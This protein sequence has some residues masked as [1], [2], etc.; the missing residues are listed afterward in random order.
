MEIPVL[1][2]FER[3]KSQIMTTH[4]NKQ[5]EE[6]KWTCILCP[7]IKKKVD[8]N[9]EFSKYSFVDGARDGLFAVAEMFNATLATL[10]G[11]DVDK[12]TQAHRINSATISQE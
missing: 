9:V 4:Y 10:Y 3:I 2:M 7:K 1:S 8:K 11:L 12:N 5:R 6:S